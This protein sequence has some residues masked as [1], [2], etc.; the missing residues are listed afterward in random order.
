MFLSRGVSS[1]FCFREDRGCFDVGKAK[2]GFCRGEGGGEL[3]M[4]LAEVLGGEEDVIAA[5]SV[6]PIADGEPEVARRQRVDETQLGEDTRRFDER[7]ELEIGLDVGVRFGVAG[8]GVLLPLRRRIGGRLEVEELPARLEIR[9]SL[10]VEDQSGGGVEGRG[11][12]D[13]RTIDE[14]AVV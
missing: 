10:G 8:D 9:K 2:A 3:R 13:D 12:V 7:D 1:D 5:G 11:R 4:I 14:F 6:K